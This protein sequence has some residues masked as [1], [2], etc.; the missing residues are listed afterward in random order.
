MCTWPQ[1]KMSAMIT[2]LQRTGKIGPRLLARLSCRPNTSNIAPT[3]VALGSP[4]LTRPNTI[5]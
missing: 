1:H 2:G 4:E 5:H 3:E